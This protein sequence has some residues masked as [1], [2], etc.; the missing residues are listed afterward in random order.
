MK[1]NSGEKIYKKFL[2]FAYGFEDAPA[3][4]RHPPDL[5]QVYRREGLNIK[6][7]K[8]IRLID[9][10]KPEECANNECN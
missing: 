4:Q 10:I 5:K 3:T 2:G 6:V 1:G 9:F 7:S 8:L